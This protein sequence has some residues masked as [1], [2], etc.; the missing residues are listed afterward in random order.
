[1]LRCNSAMLVETL[2]KQNDDVIYFFC[3][4]NTNDPGRQDPKAVLRALV[5][6]LALRARG[7]LPKRLCETFDKRYSTGMARNGMEFDEAHELLLGLLN[8]YVRTTIVI[9]ALD[10]CSKQDRR[11]LINSLRNLVDHSTALVRVFVS[12]RGDGDIAARLKELPNTSVAESMTKTDMERFVEQEVR[13]AIQ[14]KDL[15]YGEVTPELE[16]RVTAELLAKAGGMFLWVR[17]QVQLLCQM[18]TKGQVLSLLGRLPPTLGQ[19][20][21]RIYEKIEAGPS[22]YEA[23][24]A[25]AWLMC[26]REPLRPTQWASAVSWAINWKQKD[27]Q[28][29][30][31]S[32]EALLGMCQNLVV[33]DEMQNHIAFSHISVREYL[34]RKSHFD[35]LHLECVAAE[36]CLRF[37]INTRLPRPSEVEY[38]FYKYSA[39]H[40]ISHVKATEESAP[41]ELDEFLGPWQ[42]PTIAYREWKGAV[43]LFGR[44]YREYRYADEIA[45]LTNGLLLATH[46][47]IRHTTL[48]KRSRHDP[49]AT[50]ERGLSLLALASR[51]GQQ[52]IVK[53][54]IRNGATVNP[55]RTEVDSRTAMCVY[56]RRQ[57]YSSY[58]QVD[59]CHPL[60]LAIQGGHPK[61]A[62]TLLNAGA[63]FGDVNVL[64]AAAGYGPPKVLLHILEQ[65]PSSRV[66]DRELIMAAMNDSHPQALKA[67]LS[68]CQDSVI[69]GKVIEAI[70]EHRTDRKDI[71]TQVL[72]HR[73]TASVLTGI[74]RRKRLG[75][76]TSL[77]EWVPDLPISEVVVEELALDAGPHIDCVV[78]VLRSLLLGASITSRTLRAVFRLRSGAVKMLKVLLTSKNC[79]G[80]EG[81]TKVS[82]N[83]KAISANSASL[84]RLFNENVHIRPTEYLIL[85]ALGNREEALELSKLL[86]SKKPETASITASVVEKAVIN[87]KHGVELVELLLSTGCPIPITRAAVAAERNRVCGT[88]IIELLLSKSRDMANS[89]KDNHEDLELY[90]LQESMLQLR[91]ERLKQG[92]VSGAPQASPAS[93]QQL[94][95]I[96]TE[97]AGQGGVSENDVSAAIE[98]SSTSLK[99]LEALVTRCSPLPITEHILRK[100]AMS[101]FKSLEIFRLLLADSPNVAAYDS[102]LQTAVRNPTQAYDLTKLLLE[103]A[104]TIPIS[105]GLILAIEQNRHSGTEILQMLLD[106]PKTTVGVPAVCTAAAAGKE[107]LFCELLARADTQ[108]IKREYGSIFIA[109]F[110]SGNLDVLGRCIDYGGIWGGTDEHGWNADLMACHRQDKALLS[111]I[112]WMIGHR[113]ATPLPPSAWEEPESSSVTLF[114]ST[115]IIKGNSNSD[116]LVR[117]NHPMIPIGTSYFEVQIIQLDEPEYYSAEDQESLAIGVIDKHMMYNPA[118]YTDTGYVHDLFLMSEHR[119]FTQGDTVGFGVDWVRKEQFITMNGVLGMNPLSYYLDLSLSAISGSPTLHPAR[120]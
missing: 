75:I 111:R 64:S 118:Y 95:S 61:V 87:E 65:D 112:R 30:R 91:L 96:Q 51:N 25:L 2:T 83:S 79:R 77:L 39:R 44:R 71:V 70:F 7:G 3:S 43:E 48:W 17:L 81:E 60:F 97:G 16:E 47:G 1:M 34:E 94:L 11:S 31:I 4:R 92:S 102:V 23:H 115:M 40:W 108:S 73:I 84:Q 90:R 15:L 55:L 57:S 6:Q 99:S 26:A 49:N 113:S 63:T 78:E 105:R 114:G 58:V 93:R 98:D 21:D 117:A 50:D 45:T 86:L 9:D 68:A 104:D 119:G 36:T 103:R 35:E 106:S 54:L 120:S 14:Y 82:N 62:M 28:L 33:F 88:K 76:L 109:A 110:D 74:W 101:P 85:A 72:A 37:L 116:I 5:H 107:T 53:L 29:S 12:S 67:C 100:A 89:S 20:Y 27:T 32:A 10:E 19:T 59:D 52:R 42:A 13:G 66:S 80:S 22:A 69:T 8:G 18:P 41:P 56:N 24:Q 46:Y 38:G